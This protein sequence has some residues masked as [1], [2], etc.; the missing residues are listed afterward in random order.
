MKIFTPESFVGKKYLNFHYSLVEREYFCTI[1]ID[2]S[3][4]IKYGKTCYIMN[5]G[6][7]QIPEG[8][9][10]QF[11]V[12]FDENI[13]YFKFP[14]NTRYMTNVPEYYI[15]IDTFYK[16]ANDNYPYNGLFFK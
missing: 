8:G 1:E 2:Y 11:I 3:F 4:K 10:F 6:H 14:R 15:K 16:H 7:D 12:R 5:I 9:Y 13:K